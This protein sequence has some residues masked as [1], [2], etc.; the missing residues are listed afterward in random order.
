[1]ARLHTWDGASTQGSACPLRP[2]AC[3][4]RQDAGV[5]PEGQPNPRGSAT[6]RKTHITCCGFKGDT[7]WEAGNPASVFYH[8]PGG[9]V[10]RSARQKCCVCMF[11]TSEKNL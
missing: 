9:Q 4:G 8:R 10:A 2:Q 1:M 7:P 5:P 11:G 3:K 6:P